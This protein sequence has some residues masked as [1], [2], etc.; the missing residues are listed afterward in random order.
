MTINSSYGSYAQSG[1]MQGQ[2]PSAPPPDM[3]SIT[4]E[5]IASYDSDQD[6]ALSS[7][8]FIAAAEENGADAT[9]AQDAFTSLDTSGEGS[10][11]TE[12]L[13]SA[14]QK[15]RPEPSEGMAPP[16]PPP[17]PPNEGGSVSQA[18]LEELF[19]QLDTDG[20]GTISSEEFLS[21]ASQD[22]TTSETSTA[23]AASENTR[24]TASGF[25]QSMQNR[26]FQALL[27]YNS[28]ETSELSA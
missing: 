5:L 15:S 11:S 24:N 22:S 21:A 4:E 25:T 23:A 8:E 26:L 3:Q 10:L 28:L 17:P 6:G 14:L 18:D 16:P 2:R 9:T 20:D 27:N 1:M 12:E 13:L 7:E 19:T